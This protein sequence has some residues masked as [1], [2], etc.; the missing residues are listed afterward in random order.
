CQG[1][2][3]A[4]DPLD[5]VCKPDGTTTR[6]GETCKTAGTGR[7]CG[8]MIGAWCDNEADDG[9]PGGYCSYEPCSAMRP[10]PVGSSCAGLGGLPPACWKSCATGA[11]C[12]VPD[13]QCVDVQALWVT[14][15]SHKVCYLPFFPC[16]HDADCPPS[17]P[18]CHGATPMHQGLCSK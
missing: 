17:A 8:A 9:F 16:F 11:D 12:R 1:A 18:G 4:C 10:C 13:Y 2:A 6:I 5:G 3:F 14:G 15:P 7:E